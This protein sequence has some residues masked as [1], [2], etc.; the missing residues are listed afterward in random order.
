M[1]RL[2]AKN[3]GFLASAKQQLNPSTYKRVLRIY[4]AFSN[5]PYVT[6]GGEWLC[7]KGES[8]AKAFISSLRVEFKY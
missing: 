3:N 8:A 6:E 1:K 2:T 7:D 4:N 5:N